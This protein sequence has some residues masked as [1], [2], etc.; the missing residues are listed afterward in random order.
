MGMEVELKLSASAR[1]LRDLEELPWLR[2]IAARTGRRHNLISVYFDTPR[3]KFAR[4]GVTLRI[5]RDGAQRIQTIKA[6]PKRMSSPSAGR[7]FAAAPFARP[8]WE[9]PVPSDQPVLSLAEGTAL[10]PLLGRKTAERLKPVFETR[11]RRTTIL[12]PQGTSV[13]ELAIDRG[14]IRAGGQSMRVSEVELELKSGD[15]RAI[16]ELAARLARRCPLRYAPLSKAERGYAL[17]YRIAAAAGGRA[18]GTRRT[19]GAVRAVGA[20]AVTLDRRASAA[21]ALQSIGF[22]CLRHLALNEDR[23]H[24]GDPE[25]I[26]QMR[27]G[28]R[29]LQA[30]IA[31]FKDLLGDAQSGRIQSECRWLRERLGPARDLDVLV[32]Q[33]LAPFKTG[34]ARRRE[35][36]GLRRR[37]ET[38]RRAELSLAGD[39]VRSE[40]YRRFVLAVALWL[41]GGGWSTRRG[42]A[43]ALRA[44]PV[45]EFA[46]QVLDHRA[47]KL[48]KGVRRLD[49]LSDDRRHAVR[50]AAKKLRYGSEFFASLFSQPRRDAQ[51]RRYLAV[52]KT[53]QDGLGRLNDLAVQGRIARAL[54]PRE[55]AAALEL[56][57]ERGAVDLAPLLAAAV[58]AA[59]RL[60]RAPEFWK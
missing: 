27:V 22:S 36:A 23:V 13:I 26:H 49:R 12:V 3:A 17:A 44:Q 33:G 7:S 2:K 45:V 58:Q 29:R 40:R 46:R 19:A 50:I 43:A 47:R 24:E 59:A 1:A 11:I 4:H 54:P 28:L 57:A 35:L 34:A 38:Q 8:E 39:A 52:L 15:P 21:E 18:S 32:R 10:A 31:C 42:P 53:L 30:A 37:L 55:A 60:E 25:A 48:R 5:R 20:A 41:A 16:L 14:S 9:A 6:D 51:R 56:L